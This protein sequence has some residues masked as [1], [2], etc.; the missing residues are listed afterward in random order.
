MHNENVTVVN[1][2]L[3]LF[4]TLYVLARFSEQ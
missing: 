1:W 4:A 2:F 3:E